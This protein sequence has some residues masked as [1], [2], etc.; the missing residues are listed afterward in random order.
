MK[1][2]DGDAP[3]IV[4]PDCPEA[5]RSLKAEFDK[6]SRMCMR[7]TR[8]HELKHVV[9]T[10]RQSN[11]TRTTGTLAP[12]RQG[13]IDEWFSQEAGKRNGTKQNSEAKEEPTKTG[14]QHKLSPITPKHSGLNIF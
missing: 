5:R 12:T 3:T 14:A 9:K 6:E 1:S 4:Y 13:K 10:P 2:I 7:Q 8:L 11:I